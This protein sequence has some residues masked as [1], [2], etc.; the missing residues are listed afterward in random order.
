MLFI[1]V[2]QM[3]IKFP[4]PSVDDFVKQFDDTC[5]DIVEN[6]KLRLRVAVIDHIASS[7]AI[8]YPIEAIS[9]Q[10]KH[11]LNIYLNGK[12]FH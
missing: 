2:L 4:I 12:N 11:I 8:M 10:N 9:K 6:K 3:N 1:F 7:T 5:R